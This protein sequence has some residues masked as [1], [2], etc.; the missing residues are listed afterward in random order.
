MRVVLYYVFGFL[1][2]KFTYE[3][4]YNHHANLHNCNH[5]LRLGGLGNLS[6]ESFIHVDTFSMYTS[7]R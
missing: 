4:T 3:S 5:H 7:T 6:L 2:V 1:K